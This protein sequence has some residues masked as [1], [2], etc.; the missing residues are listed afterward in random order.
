MFQNFLQLLPVLPNALELFVPK[1]SFSCSCKIVLVLLYSPIGFLV[2]PQGG[3]LRTP[4]H[5]SSHF[6]MLLLYFLSLHL[7]FVL[8]CSRFVSSAWASCR[9]VQRGNFGTCL[10]ALYSE[11]KSFCYDTDL[12]VIISSFKW[13]LSLQFV[14]WYLLIGLKFMCLPFLN[15]F[16]KLC[17]QWNYFPFKT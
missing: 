3:P 14:A 11:S 17:E 7:T 15:L 12:C 10:T 6:S 8:I 5:F 2:F 9:L 1:L 13:L 4:E 16:I